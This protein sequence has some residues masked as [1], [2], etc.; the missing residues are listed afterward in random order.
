MNTLSNELINNIISYNNDFED[1]II[2]KYINKYFY[3]IFIN[4]VDSIIFINDYNDFDEYTSYET[5]FNS[6]YTNNIVIINEIKQL[7]FIN[8]KNIKYLH[9][10]YY[11]RVYKR[12]EEYIWFSEDVLELFINL[13]YLSID[14]MELSY[15]PKN[16]INLEYLD[17]SENFITRIPK[18][19][20][21]LNTII[22]I[23]DFTDGLKCIPQSIINE[24]EYIRCYSYLRHDVILNK[25][26]IKYAF[27]GLHDNCN[28]YYKRINV[29]MNNKGIL[30]KVTPS[31][32]K[33][34]KYEYDIK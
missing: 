7:N 21:K 27:I 30:E 31:D 29:Y 16:L 23:N 11:E 12:G 1:L 5:E 8:P 33:I 13:K 28:N 22:C 2:I 10:N 34:C 32:L 4:W 17:V 19:L 18:E 3:D 9:L 14:G 6:S 26:K 24:L 20:I 25:D 15:I